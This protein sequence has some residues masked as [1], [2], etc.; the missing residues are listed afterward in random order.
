MP[1][2][3]ARAQSAQQKRNDKM[4]LKEQDRQE[5]RAK[6]D[7]MREEEQTGKDRQTTDAK[8]IKPEQQQ[9]QS[10]C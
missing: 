2:S 3:K 7:G 10:K 6:D 9:S 4:E 8:P 5:T 1:I